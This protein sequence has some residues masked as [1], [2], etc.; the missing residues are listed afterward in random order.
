MKCKS[1]LYSS[2]KIGK[3]SQVQQY[4]FTLTRE[5]HPL[6]AKYSLNLLIELYKKQIWNEA[7]TVNVISQCCFTKITKVLAL[8][9]QFFA[10]KDVEKES[11]S[12]SESEDEKTTQQVML[13]LRVGKK[14]KSRKKRTD[15]ALK[16]INKDKK[17]KK[18]GNDIPHFSA[19][20]LIYD[21]QDFAEKLFKLVDTTNEG[22]EIKISILDL[23]SRLIGIHQL[24]LNNFHHFLIRFLNPHQREVTKILWFSAISSHDLTP[25]DT[26]EPVLMAIANNFITER[27]STEVIAVGLNAIREICGRCPLAMSEDLLGDLVLYKTYKD[28]AVS[29]AAKSLIQLFRE[30]NPQMLHRKMR[31]KPTEESIAEFAKT[32]QYG[33][34]DAKS[35]VPGAEIIDLE[36]LK[37]KEPEKTI[38]IEDSDEEGGEWVESES[39]DEKPKKRKHSEDEEEENSEGEWVDVSSDGEDEDNSEQDQN[40]LMSLVEKEEKAQ[41]VSTERILTQEE[42]KKIRI[43]QMKKKLTDRN[44]DKNSKNKKIKIDSD[45]EEDNERFKNNGLVPLSSITYIN[46]KRAHDKETRMAKVKEGREGRDKFGHRYKD[47]N[48]GKTNKEKLKTKS[49]QMLRPKLNKK[50]RRSFKEKQMAMQSNE[51]TD[52]LNQMGINDSIENPVSAKYRNKKL[53]HKLKKYESIIKKLDNIKRVDD[54]SQ[55]LFVGNC[56]LDNNISADFIEEKF[57]TFGK[58]IDI[59][60]QKKKPYSFI[61]FEEPQSTQKAINQLQSQVITTNN[62]TTLCFYLFPVD[63][64][65]QTTVQFTEFEEVECLPK[66]IDYLEDYIQDSYAKKIV[67]FFT[68]QDENQNSVVG[69]KRRRV[70][71]F[72]YEF[73]YGSNNCDDT[74]PLTDP[75]NKMPQVL[76]ELFE[77][78]LNDKLIHVKP[79]QLTVNF[80]EP[81]QGIGPH[82]DNTVAF[83]NFIISLSLMSSTMMEFRQKETK[84]ISKILLKPNSLLVLKGESRFNWS[85]SIPERKHDLF[86][87]SN[88]GQYLVLKRNMRISLTFRKVIPLSEQKKKM[89]KIDEPQMTIPSTD[90]EAKNFEKSFVQ[91]IYNEIADHFSHTRHSAW[92]GVNRFITSMEPRSFMIDIGCGNGKYLNLRNDLYSFG[93]DFSEGLIRICNERNFNC[94]VSDCL[95]VPVKTDFFDYSICIAVIH[96]LSTEERR[97]KSINEMIRILKPGGRCLITVWAKEQKYKEKES[98]YISQKKTSDEENQDSNIHTF[99]K[100][101][102]KKDVFVAWHYNEKTL[103]KSGDMSGESKPSDQKNKESKVFL[104]YYHVFEKNELEKLFEKIDTAKIIESYYEQGNWCVIFEKNLPI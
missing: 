16:S 12:E 98:F 65:P 86:K 66:G 2:S 54:D 28:K 36:S 76:D 7:K 51:I 59:I 88:S 55:F 60:M 69:L 95:C 47:S 71:H 10:G 104:R 3:K 11:E 78:M 73:K 27:N 40:K 33:E 84:K 41:K 96:H 50:H 64:V 85:H 102:Q 79:D 14:T 35:Y 91:S 81:G 43:E 70:K 48:L 77:K 42:F 101:F 52:N 44:F 26:V 20:N 45:I 4:V 80:Y 29:S 87:D 94:F 61:I 37:P 92:P 8:A 99:G 17:K 58:I 100:E 74:K 9:L 25:P 103:K 13:S 1:S 63:K 24:F 22:F 30:K 19:L 46:K 53:E 18:K 39:E 23:I 31:G 38:N 90:F 57:R 75:E 6:V 68:E 83:D 97:I 5:N 21:P 15:R 49:F 32:R 72:G 34:L 82:I 89:E 62:Q 56:G 67:D 93:C